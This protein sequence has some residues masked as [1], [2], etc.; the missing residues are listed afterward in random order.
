MYYFCLFVCWI[1][2]TITW[3]LVHLWKYSVVD[4]RIINIKTANKIHV[5]WASLHNTELC[6]FGT[7]RSLIGFIEQKQEKSKQI[8]LK[9]KERSLKDFSMKEV[10]TKKSVFLKNSPYRERM[11]ILTCIL[12]CKNWIASLSDAGYSM[13]GAGAWGWPGE[14]L[15]GGRWEGGSCLGMHVRIKDFKI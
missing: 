15:W 2:V 10:K 12:S 7:G 6:N 5:F 13:L 14:M 11:Y 1:N 9:K 4:F 8:N 3:I